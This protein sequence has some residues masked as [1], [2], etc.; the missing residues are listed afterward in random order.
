MHDLQHYDVWT[1]TEH[2]N[3]IVCSLW[4]LSGCFES[5]WLALFAPKCNRARSTSLAPIPRCMMIASS[6]RSGDEGATSKVSS[7]VFSKSAY[8]SMRNKFFSPIA[9]VPTSIKHCLSLPPSFMLQGVT[10][11]TN[12][13]RKELELKLGCKSPP[14]LFPTRLERFRSAVKG[15][16]WGQGLA[17]RKAV[18]V[19]FLEE[20]TLIRWKKWW[21]HNPDV[22]TWRRKWKLVW[23][24]EQRLRSI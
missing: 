24:S 6:W 13:Y 20:V 16:C 12:I 14:P 4:S 18:N 17:D 15:T 11:G 2:K 1:S 9:A 10:R 19:V 3:D 23:L 5:V 21:S 22:E 7:Y 8:R